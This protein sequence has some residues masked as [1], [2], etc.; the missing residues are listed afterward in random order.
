[1]AVRGALGVVCID[2]M[3]SLLG[4]RHNIPPPASASWKAN[5]LDSSVAT[6]EDSLK[7]GSME[8]LLG[9]AFMTRA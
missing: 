3:R 6:S 2:D 4:T 7:D 5:T 9:T 8:E 1:M